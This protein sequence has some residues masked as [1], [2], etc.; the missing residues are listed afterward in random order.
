METPDLS[1]RRPRA[2]REDRDAPSVVDVF[3]QAGFHGLVSIGLG[4]IA[5]HPGYQREERR[6]DHPVGHQ[7]LDLREQCRNHEHIQGGLMVGHHDSGSAFPDINLLPVRSESAEMYERHHP[8]HQ[9]AASVHPGRNERT[10]SFPSQGKSLNENAEKQEK[11]A[12]CQHRNIVIYV[13]HK[14]P[15]C[16]RR[17][18]GGGRSSDE[19]IENQRLQHIGHQ[20]YGY[21][22]ENGDHSD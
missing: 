15:Q 13:P 5:Q 14:G 11:E 10:P 17:L 22:S 20:H 18:A 1:V 21:H 6:L 9:P 2:F 7:E 16:I 19:D 3:L 8:Q 4:I 12:A